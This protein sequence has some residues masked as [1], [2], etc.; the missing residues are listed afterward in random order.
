MESAPRRLMEQRC[1][2][3]QE[4]NG[5]LILHI[6]LRSVINMSN[7]QEI[8]PPWGL[9]KCVS[10]PAGP[11]FANVRQACRVGRPP[12][13]KHLAGGGHSTLRIRNIHARPFHRGFKVVPVLFLIRVVTGRKKKSSQ[14]Q[15]PSPSTILSQEFCDTAKLN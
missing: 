3:C 12:L 9:T 1:F 14:K 15:S 4:L 5:I 6:S 13:D 2:N 8:K 7:V 10:E 11:T